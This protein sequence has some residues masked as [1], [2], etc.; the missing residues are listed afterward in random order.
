MRGNARKNNKTIKENNKLL[1]KGLVDHGSYIKVQFVTVCLTV[2][3]EWCKFYEWTK[4][5]KEEA[6]IAN[7]AKYL[8]VCR[9]TPF[10]CLFVNSYIY[11]Y[12]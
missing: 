12:I 4:Q 5:E 10:F 8:E 3:E 2:A 1:I 6:T 11:I 7:Y 9:L